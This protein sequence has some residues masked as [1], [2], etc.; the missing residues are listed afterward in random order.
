MQPWWED[1]TGFKTFKTFYQSSNFWTFQSFQVLITWQTQRFSIFSPK[2]IYFINRA[3]YIT[4]YVQALLY[5]TN[6]TFSCVS[7]VIWFHCIFLLHFLH[8]SGKR[9]YETKGGHLTNCTS[10]DPARPWRWL[11][12]TQAREPST[13]W[14]L[15]LLLPSCICLF[16]GK[17]AWGFARTKLSPNVQSEI[18]H[19]PRNSYK[20]MCPDQLRRSVLTNRPPMQIPQEACLCL[21][22]AVEYVA[23]SLKAPFEDRILFWRI[24]QFFF[25]RLY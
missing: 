21:F 10:D 17:K 8:T 12:V 23:Q 20:Q 1:D 3:D 16:R 13:R 22:T 4:E 25:C 24:P 14:T 5:D 7:P 2:N 18:T 15:A 9:R 11:F 6:W 19:L